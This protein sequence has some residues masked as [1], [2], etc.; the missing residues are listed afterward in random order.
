MRSI[1]N[2]SSRSCVERK[3]NF[4]PSNIQK[5]GRV[6]FQSENFKEY[7]FLRDKFNCFWIITLNFLLL[8]VQ[9]NNQINLKNLI[10]FTKKIYNMIIFR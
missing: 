9:F 10:K 4:Y 1:Y 8:V 2:Y 7:K 6:R 3:W 5:T